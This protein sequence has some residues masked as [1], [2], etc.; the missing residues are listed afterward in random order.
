MTELELRQP[1][2]VLARRCGAIG[3]LPRLATAGLERDV[4]WFDLNHLR[5]RR[6]GIVENRA[7]VADPL[8]VALGAFRRPGR[9]VHPGRISVPTV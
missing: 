5:L 7:P 4:R 1:W 9:G 2:W 6:Q 8:P 3:E